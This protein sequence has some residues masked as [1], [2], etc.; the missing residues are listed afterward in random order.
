MDQAKELRARRLYEISLCKKPVVLNDSVDEPPR[1]VDA[2]RGDSEGEAEAGGEV[3]PPP[4]CTGGDSQEG[5]TSKEVGALLRQQQQQQQQQRPTQRPAQRPAQRPLDEKWGVDVNGQDAAVDLDGD[6]HDVRNSSNCGNGKE[7]NS[8]TEERSPPS[9]STTMSPATSA[10]ASASTTS[11][12]PAYATSKPRSMSHMPPPLPPRPGVASSA[13]KTATSTF[14]TSPIVAPLT[15]HLAAVPAIGSGVTK[16]DGGIGGNDTIGSEA[17]LGKPSER[18]ERPGYGASGGTPGSAGNVCGAARGVRSDNAGS[19]KSTAEGEGPPLAA[20]EGDVSEG[21]ALSADAAVSRSGA[22]LLKPPAPQ[23]LVAGALAGATPGSRLA[24][25]PASAMASRRAAL[26]NSSSGGGNSKACTRPR[27]TVDDPCEVTVDGDND[28]IGPASVH[29]D[30]VSRDLLPAGVSSSAREKR[31]QG[32]GGVL[33]GSTDEGATVAI[34]RLG[35]C[36]EHPRPATTLAKTLV[37]R[38]RDDPKKREGGCLYGADGMSEDGG[39]CADCDNGGGG[40]IAPSEG[41]YMER[42]MD[43]RSKGTSG[44]EGGAKVGRRILINKIVSDDSGSCSVL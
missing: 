20:V 36:G 24:A 37:D 18:T 16:I 2:G 43:K 41:E 42:V 29:T 14:Q 39:G 4:S 40:A 35:S 32:T 38:R 33:N 17:N 15:G 7:D 44:N 19:G 13:S 28:L 25:I 11:F 6:V 9:L 26:I 22:A 27:G 12:N 10:S 3:L 30:G 31:A 1:S 23:M 21:T 34:K 5:S 8:S